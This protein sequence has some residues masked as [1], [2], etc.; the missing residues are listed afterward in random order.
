MTRNRYRRTWATTRKGIKDRDGWRCQKCGKAGRL[1][2]HHL[3]HNAL[4]DDPANLVTWCRDC[5]IKH[6]RRRKTAMERE[7]DRY[8][9]G[10]K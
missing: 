5:H 9:A 2:V 6:H 4:N 1:E 8:L 7:W 10:F 3:D